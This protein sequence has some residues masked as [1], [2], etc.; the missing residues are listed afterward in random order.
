M[1]QVDAK[2]GVQMQFMI[3]CQIVLSTAETIAFSV[4]GSEFSRKQVST[5]PF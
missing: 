3:I 5:L 2:S 1:V 4:D